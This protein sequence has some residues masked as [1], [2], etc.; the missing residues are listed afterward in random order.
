[1]V[2]SSFRILTKS[3]LR[4]LLNFNTVDV[5]FAILLAPDSNS[6]VLNCLIPHDSAIVLLAFYCCNVLDGGVLDDSINPVFESHEISLVSDFDKSIF[7][8]ICYAPDISAHYYI[9]RSEIVCADGRP[10][11]FFSDQ[12]LTISTNIQ[13]DLINGFLVHA[14]EIAF[15]VIQTSLLIVNFQSANNSQS[16]QNNR[17]HKC[18]IFKTSNPNINFL[19]LQGIPLCCCRN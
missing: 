13:N 16:Y 10:P 7:L 3:L 2:I 9:L 11:N 15:R 8:N 14:D 17:S 1:M 19:S 18:I 12:L 5:V 4:Y 6:V